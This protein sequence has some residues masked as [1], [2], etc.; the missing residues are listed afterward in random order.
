MAMANLF[1]SAL[2]A[3]A[4]AGLLAAPLARGLGTIPATRAD[5]APQSFEARWPPIQDF[6]IPP[7]VQELQAP[8]PKVIATVPLL[9]PSEFGGRPPTALA[10]TTP[11]ATTRD[12]VCGPRGRTWYRNENG[13]R[14][15][16]C[17]R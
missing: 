17:N 1:A 14:Y 11:G 13:W 10:A 3:S 7:P 9:P 12:P 15:W 5:F 8:P 6:L 16:R 4:A 2:I